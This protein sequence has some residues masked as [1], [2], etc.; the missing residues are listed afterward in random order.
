MSDTPTIAGVS[1]GKTSAFMAMHFVQPDT[2]LCFQNTGLEHPKTYEFLQRVQDAI[3]RE[4][5]WLEWRPAVFGDTPKHFQHARVNP[6]EA[7]RGG[8][9]ASTECLTDSCWQKPPSEPPWNSVCGQVCA[10][11]TW[12]Q[13][14]AHVW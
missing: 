9:E 1:G 13:T 8:S 6:E 4:I 12:L 3:G 14:G 10:W 5:V 11:M 7:H 2:V